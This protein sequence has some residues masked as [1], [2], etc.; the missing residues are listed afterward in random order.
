MCRQLHL[1]GGSLLLRLASAAS[2]H[3]RLP[4]LHLVPIRIQEPAEPTIR[5][6]FDIA[7]DLTPTSPNLLERLVEV[8]N[9]QIDDEWLRRW[10]EVAGGSWKDAPHR[11]TCLGHVSRLEARRR[12]PLQ[13]DA[14]MPRIP[15]REPSRMRGLEKDATDSDSLRHSLLLSLEAYSSQVRPTPG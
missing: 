14:E 13:C 7:N 12:L 15:R 10:P 3:G 5:V 4:E 8:V 2:P 1:L 6:L 9:D 11:E